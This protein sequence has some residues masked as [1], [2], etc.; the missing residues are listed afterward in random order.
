MAFAIAGRVDD[1]TRK[2]GEAAIMWY[3]RCSHTDSASV[4]VR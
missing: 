3:R 1:V 2:D 4:G